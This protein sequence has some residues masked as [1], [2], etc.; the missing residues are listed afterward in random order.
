[1]LIE[2]IKHPLVSDYLH[3]YTGYSNTY[4]NTSGSSELNDFIKYLYSIVGDG[5]FAF[6]PLPSRM[7]TTT[8]NQMFGL[9]TMATGSPITFPKNVIRSESGIV[10]GSLNSVGIVDFSINEKFQFRKNEVSIFYFFKHNRPTDTRVYR[11][12]QV[13]PYFWFDDSADNFGVFAP[14]F[15]SSDLR[16]TGNTY[17]YDE[18]YGADKKGYQM[19]YSA[20]APEKLGALTDTELTGADRFGTGILN[21]KWPPVSFYEIDNNEDRFVCIN[22]VI[23]KDFYSLRSFFGRDYRVLTGKFPAAR[24]SYELLDPETNTFYIDNKFPKRIVIGAGVKNDSISGYDIPGTDHTCAGLIVLEGDYTDKASEIAYI[25]SETFKIKSRPPISSLSPNNLKDPV[26]L[27]PNILSVNYYDYR[28]PI[29]YETSSNYNDIINYNANISRINYINYGIWVYEVLQSTTGTLKSPI[30]A[31]LLDFKPEIMGIVLISGVLSVSP[32]AFG[33]LYNRGVIGFVSGLREKKP[34]SDDEYIFT[35]FTEQDISGS[36]GFYYTNAIGNVSQIQI[37]PPIKLGLQQQY[38]TGY[39]SG[40][41]DPVSQVFTPFDSV[42]DLYSS[43]YFNSVGHKSYPELKIIT[44]YITGYISG[45]LFENNIFSGFDSNYL[46]CS[47]GY[48]YSGNQY[49]FLPEKNINTQPVTGFLVGVKSGDTFSGFYQNAEIIDLYSG[50]FSINDG[51]N[52]AE[53]NEIVQIY[54]KTGEEFSG[55]SG[56]GLDERLGFNY[57]GFFNPVLDINGN[58]L[59]DNNNNPIIQSFDGN[60][61]FSGAQILTEDQ[62]L[63]VMS[64]IVGSRNFL[65]FNGEFDGFNNIDYPNTNYGFEYSGFFASN[66]GFVGTEIN[67]DTLEINTYGTGIMTGLIGY[68][69]KDTYVG[70]YDFNNNPD[71]PDSGV[72]T[73]FSFPLGSGFSGLFDEFGTGIQTGIIGSKNKFLLSGS[74]SGFTGQSGFNQ[75]F[76]DAINIDFNF[77]DGSGFSGL[78]NSQTGIGMM[79]GL[80][81]TGRSPFLFGDPIYFA[82]QIASITYGGN[83]ISGDVSDILSTG[84]LA[85]ITGI[86]YV[87]GYAT[88]SAINSGSDQNGDIIVTG[89]HPEILG[90]N[91]F[92]ASYM[93]KYDFQ[94]TDYILRLEAYEGQELESGVRNAINNLISGLKTDNIWD[95][96]TNA[97]LLAGP[98][99]RSGIFVPLKNGGK[100]GQAY[101]FTS[102]D[103]NR[104]SGLIGDGSSKYVNTNILLN[105][106]STGNQHMLV[107]VTKTGFSQTQCYIGA[108]IQDTTGSSAIYMS[109]SVLYQ[110][111]RA[112]GLSPYGNFGPSTGMMA[113][114]RYSTGVWVARNTNISETSFIYLENGAQP[115]NIYVFANN[116]TGFGTGAPEHYSDARIAIYSVGKNIDN[117]SKF[118]QRINTYLDSIKSHII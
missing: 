99:T 56:M 107:Y 101:N 69:N 38:V 6:Y 12:G 67:P 15:S 10:L 105:Q 59:L 31:D 80:I 95:K 54:F 29:A 17:L 62:I 46:D 58:P 4:L 52:A 3:R 16:T 93:D 86:T 117:L 61:G 34:N 25:T 77:Y 14:E 26:S 91:Y 116:A 92:A 114:S 78:Y 60:S 106:E 76:L 2:D 64:G 24:L 81:T 102:I 18:I 40:Y 68:I 33:S 113:T 36:S 111:S 97:C 39:I 48:Y 11:E 79:S 118:E 41:K 8:G 100:T 90:V 5:N 21:I 66:S 32:P 72:F 13:C 27:N 9:G 83:F 37:F 85:Q 28:S 98:K 104:M 19:D 109:G 55:L 44:E 71:F 89:L 88:G 115:S 47:S 22:T 42:S 63:G 84:L 50:I 30:P 70:L 57:T 49:E 108:G 82:S 75:G 87:F 43:G 35:R 74:F 51:S 20:P 96:I 23:N 1:M 112:S 103:Y 45:F 94:A 65:V 53:V 110:K 7:N 73:G